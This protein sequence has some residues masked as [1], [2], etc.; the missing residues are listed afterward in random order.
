M[1][2]SGVKIAFPVVFALIFL[3]SGCG[4]TVVPSPQNPGAIINPADRSI[5]EIRNGLEISAR[6]QELSVGSYGISE[7]ITSFYLV[8]VNRR[9][10]E[11][12]VP[13]KALYLLDDQGTQ[14]RPILPENVLATLDRQSDYLIP[15]PYVGYYYLEDSRKAVAIDS[16]GSSLPY[17]ASNYPQ[18]LLTEALP[19]SPVLPGARIAGMVYFPVDLATKKSV[20]LKIYLPGT[21]ISAP[22]DFR[23]PFSIEKN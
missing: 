4:I 17:Y 19:D 18:E 22:P 14:L 9:D 16:M 5:T 7:N 23:F 12:V 20:E 3:L 10:Q 21:P 2:G 6:V 11:A 13:L 15:Y 1:R 8:I